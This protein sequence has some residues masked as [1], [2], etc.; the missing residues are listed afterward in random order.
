MSVPV[1]V[2]DLG[3]HI[4]DRGAVAYLLTVNDDGRAH[5]VSVAVVVSGGTLECGAG[6]RTAANV[7]ARPQISLLWPARVA[8]EH[9]LIVD[10]DAVVSGAGDDQRVVMSP[11]RA[12][13]HRSADC[14]PLDVRNP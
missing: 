7:S 5:A 11:T 13:L 2:T 4:A 10:V 14:V 6:R 3:P 9:S 12:V 1:E 8:D